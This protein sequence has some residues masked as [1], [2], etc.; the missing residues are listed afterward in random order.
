MK[1]GIPEI[2]AELGIPHVGAEHRHGRQGWVQVD[3]PRCGRGSQKYHLGISLQTGAANCWRCGP[4]DTAAALATLGNVPYSTARQLLSTAKR[5][6]APRQ[7]P[8]GRLRPPAG[9][10]PLGPGHRAYLARRGF[11]PDVVARLW[12]VRGIGPVGPYRYR[13]Y[14][15]IYH[16]G[17]VVS[18]TTRATGGNGPRYLSAPAACEAMPAKKLLYGADYARHAVVIHEGPLDVWATGPGAVATLGT[19]FTDAQVAALARYPVRVVCFDSGPAAQRRARELADALAP[20]RGATYSVVLET[21][22]D[23]AA[24]DTDEL[25]ELR[26]RYLDGGQPAARVP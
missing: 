15:P 6:P 25:A 7:R 3:C 19:G 21:G 10:G 2:L 11:R 13:L 24:A 12:G 23:A 22:E 5:L 26:R 8:R 17:Q 14:I 20:F 9:V 1:P 16:H 4:Q 18:W